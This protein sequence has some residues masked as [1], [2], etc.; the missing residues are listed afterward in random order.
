MPNAMNINDP[1]ELAAEYKRFKEI[2]NGNKNKKA[3]NNTKKSNNG[4]KTNKNKKANN[5]STRRVT[6][7][8]AKKNNL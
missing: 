1:A 7:S 6:R 3:N 8:Q 4:K 2:H 5:T